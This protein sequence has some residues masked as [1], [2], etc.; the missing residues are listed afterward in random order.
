MEKKPFKKKP[1]GRP[2][3]VAGKAPFKPQTRAE[4]PPVEKEAVEGM[5]LNKYVAHCGICSRRQAADYVKDGFVEVNGEVVREP[6]Y[7]VKESDKVAFKGKPIQPEE[8][9]VYILMN[10]PRGVITTVRD[11]R[12]RKTVLDLVKPKVKERIYPVGRLDRDTT[13]L[14]LLTNDGELAKKLAHP[15]HKIQKFYHVVLDRPLSLKDLEKI[16]EGLVLEDGP[17][18]I[19]GI[20]YLRDTSKNEVGIEIHIGKNRIVRRVFEHLGYTVEKLDRT[21]YAGLT[22]KDLPRGHF[23]QLSQREIIMLKHFTGK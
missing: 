22:K 13:G 4:R 12:E 18:E 9:K 16:R 10:K 8:K 15:S 20:D 17:A 2:R 1:A 11:E 3:P 19:D 5:R 21:Y 23:R 7:Q 6:F 14:L